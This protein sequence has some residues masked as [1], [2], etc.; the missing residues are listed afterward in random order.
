[1]LARIGELLARE[2]QHGK[3]PRKALG[4]S[5]RCRLRRRPAICRTLES[6]KGILK[7]AKVA[8]DPCASAVSAL[9]RCAL[10]QLERAGNALR[11][12]HHEALAVEDED[13]GKA[14][15][16][17]GVVAR[18]HG[19]VAGEH[20][21]RPSCSAEKRQLEHRAKLHGILVA[22]DGPSPGPRAE[23]TLMPL[24]APRRS[25]V[26]YPLGPSPTPQ[27]RMLARTHRLQHAGQHGG[28]RDEPRRGRARR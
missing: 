22:R 14:D 20:V 21:D 12:A 11:L 25:T 17:G 26:E 9:R 24:Q 23:S 19:D 13:A 16:E 7:R 18:R 2:P 27:I 15:A 10:P 6:S 3:R 28:G 5:C 1:V 4:S 8:A